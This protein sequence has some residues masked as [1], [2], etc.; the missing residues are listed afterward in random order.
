MIN[1]T[2]AE[3]AR[4][5]KVLDRR[6]G[7]HR[8]VRRSEG[9]RVTNPCVARR[10]PGIHG[11]NV[12]HGTKP[13]PAPGSTVRFARMTSAIGGPGRVGLAVPL[14]RRGSRRGCADGLFRAGVG[15]PHG[16]DHDAAGGRGL[17]GGGRMGVRAQ[18]R[19]RSDRVS[20]PPRLPRT[21]W[22]PAAR[23]P[24]VPGSSRARAQSSPGPVEPG[25]SWA[26]LPP[27]GRSARGE[28]WRNGA[29]R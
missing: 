18:L 12:V 16:H 13:T 26:T 9:H 3:P 23:G 8:P 6:A 10:R 14:R 15:A 17:G 4:Q 28:Y 24:V 1:T 2:E 19:P 7:P 5:R 25:S 21:T 27:G 29:E 22:C 20:G 11:H